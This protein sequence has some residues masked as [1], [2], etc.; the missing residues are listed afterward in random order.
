MFVVLS[1]VWSEAVNPSRE[2]LLEDL[3]TN[4]GT[5]LLLLSA[6]LTCVVAPMCEDSSPGYMFTS[7]RNWR[8]L[9]GGGDHR[10][11]FGGVHVGSAPALDLIPSRPRLWAVSAVPLFRVAVPCFAAHALNNCVAFAGLEHW[12]WTGGCR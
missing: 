4:E 1:A 12:G 11:I 10:L 7:L 5:T 8:G 2:K 6:A 9:A 3:G